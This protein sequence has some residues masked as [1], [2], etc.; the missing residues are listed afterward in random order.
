MAEAKTYDYVIVGAGSAGCVLARRLTEHRQCKASAISSMLKFPEPPFY[1]SL[2]ELLLFRVPIHISRN[3]F[4]E[5]THDVIGEQRLE[6]SFGGGFY[7]AR[8]H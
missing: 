6:N 8:F 4:G 3:R 5:N 1:H 2:G 7:I